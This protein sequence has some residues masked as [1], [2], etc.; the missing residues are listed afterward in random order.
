MP[1]K[2]LFQSIKGHITREKHYACNHYGK[3]F[4]HH[5]TVQQHKRTHTGE[6]SYEFYQCGKGLT[7]HSQLQGIKEHILERNPMNICVKTSAHCGGLKL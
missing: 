6:K 5:N 1:I 3:G 7:Y 2:A 4:G